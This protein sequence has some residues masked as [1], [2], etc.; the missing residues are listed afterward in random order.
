MRRAIDRLRT[1]GRGP[2]TYPA[3]DNGQRT[4]DTH[5]ATPKSRPETGAEREPPA[6]AE[7]EPGDGPDP[8]RADH[9]DRGQ[10][11]GV[12]A[13]HREADHPGEEGDAARPEAGRRAAGLAGG[14]RGQTGGRGRRRLPDGAGQAV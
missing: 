9:H 14:R 3:T 6:R 5:H 11:E 2:I 13:L 8:P 12:A 7:A 10:G 1:T 4:T